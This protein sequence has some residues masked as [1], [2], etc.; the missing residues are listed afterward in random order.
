MEDLKKL[1]LYQALVAIALNDPGSAKSRFLEL[2]ALDPDF[3][4]TG[5]A[6]SA[7][8]R[9]A[10][11][12]ARTEYLD[13][14][15]EQA[16][17]E[18][19]AARNN[20]DFDRVLPTIKK[21]RRQCDCVRQIADFVTVSLLQQGRAA[22]EGE[23]YGRALALFTKVLD[24]AP[25]DRLAS[26]YSDLTRRQI[27]TRLAQDFALWKKFFG[28]QD[29]VNAKAVYDHV[30]AIGDTESPEAVRMRAEYHS[31]LQRE[32]DLWAQACSQQDVLTADSRRQAVRA[33]D[34]SGRLN[35]DTLRQM[36]SCPAPGCTPIASTAAVSSLRSRVD[37]KL[38]P[39][40]RPYT[41]RIAVTVRIDDKGRAA[42]LD[43]DNPGGNPAVS[44]SVRDA[45][46]QWKFDPALA[47]R[48]R[49]ECVVTQFL[50]EFER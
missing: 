35:G 32:R 34:P 13:A 23:D 8:I 1:K 30:L 46:Q 38:E 43:L 33:L 25:A 28:M 36:H 22:F 47:A 27:Q 10:F 49:S 19:E 5:D 26:Q 15:C 9:D 39:A 7:R 3:S 42:V 18:C 17:T 16:C 12:E 2:V 44:Q 37:P 20:G 14:R 4:L 45:V 50:I 21:F 29:Y 31:A 24:V 48:Y 6:Y 41:S 40:A 11:A